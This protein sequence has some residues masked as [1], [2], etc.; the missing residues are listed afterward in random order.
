MNI[1]FG[2]AD[3]SIWLLHVPVILQIPRTAPLLPLPSTNNHVTTKRTGARLSLLQGKSLCLRS[4][5]G[6]SIEG[7]QQ[8]FGEAILARREGVK[9]LA[10]TTTLM[11]LTLSHTFLQLPIYITQNVHVN[12]IHTFVDLKIVSPPFI[13]QREPREPLENK[14]AYK[15]F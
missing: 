13:S 2:S 12:F 11:V 1:Y 3:S 4:P 15:Q 9:L 10:T 5:L 6:V 7:K 8:T 14:I